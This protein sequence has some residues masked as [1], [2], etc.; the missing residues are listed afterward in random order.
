MGSNYYPDVPGRR[1]AWDIDGSVMLTKSDESSTIGTAPQAQMTGANSESTLYWDPPSWGLETWG[2]VV[3]VFPDYRDISGAFICSG[4]S[5]GYL[6]DQVG[7]VQV[8]ADT[9]NGFDGTWNQIY[10]DM[11]NIHNASTWRYDIVPMTA[12][13][14]LG[15]RYRRYRWIDHVGNFHIYGKRGS[16]ASTKRLKIL[17]SNGWE[18]T[19]L[20]DYGDVERDHTV[21]TQFRVYN[22]SGFDAYDVKLSTESLT[23]DSENWYSFSTDDINYLSSLNID[24]IPGNGGTVNFYLKQ[25]LPG[26]T[27]LG[28]AAARM[29]A[30]ATVWVE[31]P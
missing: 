21:T 5:S 1:L 29:R 16:L 17:Q 14:V 28:P 4:N 27:A 8:S 30:E 24:F 6:N 2:W 13:D 25:T 26:D 19:T 9:T 23:G 12:T 11:P 15:I 20:N 7:E 18:L 22:P 31:R 3:V 10:A